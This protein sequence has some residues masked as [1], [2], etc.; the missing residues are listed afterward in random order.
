ML[1]ISEAHVCK[2][3]F[4][5]EFEMGDSAPLG[6]VSSGHTIESC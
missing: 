1:F 6:T 2:R 5:E 4:D 3:I